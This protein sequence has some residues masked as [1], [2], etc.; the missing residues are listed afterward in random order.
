M[1][2]CP[3]CNA[4]LE[5]GTTV[6]G[7]CGHNLTKKNSH[8]VTKNFNLGI[9]LK[10]GIPI[11]AVILICAIVLS[12][13]IK[14]E[15]SYSNFS[16]LRDNNLFLSD[17]NEGAG[18]QFTEHFKDKNILFSNYK[19][20]V[21]MSTDGKKIFFVDN[22]DG[23]SYKLY[24]KNTNNIDAKPIKITSDVIS[25]DISDDGA[26][27]TY[28]KDDG[29][30][31]QHN[32]SMQS[33]AID[34]DVVR[35][36]VSDNGKTILY[37]K[38][39]QGDSAQSYDLYMS[40]SGKAGSKLLSNVTGFRYISDDLS[41]VYYISNE[42]LYS[43]EV[44]KTPKKIAENVRDVIKVYESGEIYL[45]KL[46]SD[47][48]VSLFY[49]N[50]SKMSDALVKNF[51]RTEA[52]ASDKAVLISCEYS[53][54]GNSYNV[55]IKDKSF[56]VDYNATGI[57]MNSKGTEIHFIADYNDETRSAT[58]YNAKIGNDIGN[59]KKV[60]DGVF[61]GMYIDGDKFIYV[62]DYTPASV[63]GTVFVGDVKIGE[64]INYNALKY[65]KETD[66]IYYLAET[67]QNIAKL[68][69]FKNSKSKIIAESVL[70]SS[71]L[72]AETGECIYIADAYKN[73]GILY[74]AFND[75]IQQIDHD[76]TETMLIISNEEFDEK[77]LASF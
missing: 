41:T 24:Y 38:R 58:L 13:G 66:T 48:A 14:P 32:L 21:R 57:Y 72:T 73:E 54:E 9:L 20:Y 34:T 60:S 46:D 50:G 56:S 71:V 51:Y 7:A 74:S 76:V 2:S 11:I 19:D 70:V 40:K 42:V 8:G 33:K 68:G 27:V 22:F 52:V 29:V 59:I 53:E 45:T 69:M 75:K 44:G 49:Y 16:Y 65:A 26:L 55:I 10:I 25:Y 3:K 67:N 61:L 62:K 36:V 4:E 5:N 47:G 64:N 15:A 1:N 63:S 37:T 23:T 30:L 31:H 77:S 28:T 12:L 39:A 6:C 35:F 17:F 18:D 43:L